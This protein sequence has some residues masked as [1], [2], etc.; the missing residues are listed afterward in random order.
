MSWWNVLFCITSGNMN[1]KND[2][3]IILKRQKYQKKFIYLK[4]CLH[5]GNKIIIHN[6]LHFQ[7]SPYKILPHFVLLEFLVSNFSLPQLKWILLSCSTFMLVYFMYFFWQVWHSIWFKL[8]SV[9]LFLLDD[10]TTPTYCI[11]E[12]IFYRL[13]S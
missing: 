1:L 3:R 13:H 9:L 4:L 6:L 7:C 12:I 8:V 11:L 2:L 10:Q 5:S